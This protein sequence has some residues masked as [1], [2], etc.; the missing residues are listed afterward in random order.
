MYSYYMLAAIGPQMQKYLWWKKY[1]TLLQ[2][3]QKYYY[4]YYVN[5]IYSCGSQI[6]ET[7]ST[8]L[9]I[10]CK[11][12]TDNIFNV[13]PFVFQVQFIMVFIHASQLLFTEC[14][15]PKAFAWIILMHAVMFYFL[16]YNFYQQ[17][18][19]KRVSSEDREKILTIKKIAFRYDGILSILPNSSSYNISKIQLF[20]KK[21]TFW[22]L[23]NH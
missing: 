10:K 14:D 16:F 20:R 15:Y 2:M 11:L 7:C 12:Q 19:K 21:E 17:S 23:V 6:T 4:Y 13:I 22:F 5:I 8:W 9:Y 3:V 1:L 18:Y